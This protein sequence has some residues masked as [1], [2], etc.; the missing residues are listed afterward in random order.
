MNRLE[1]TD[2]TLRLTL[3][4]WILSTHFVYSFLKARTK[5]HYF[6]IHSFQFG[7]SS[8]VILFS[9]RCDLKVYM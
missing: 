2:L 7:V 8:E 1:P 9:V 4:T 5:T 3:K 6:P